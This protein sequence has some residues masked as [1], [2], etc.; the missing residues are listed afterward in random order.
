MKAKKALYALILN[1]IVLP[2]AVYRSIIDRILPPYLEGLYTPIDWLYLFSPLADLI[3]D[4]LDKL[5]KE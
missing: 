5:R 4:L 1:A 2:Y 3:F